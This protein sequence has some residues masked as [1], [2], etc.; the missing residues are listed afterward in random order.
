MVIHKPVLLKESIERLNLKSE[1][2]AVD[3]TLGGGGHSIG[4]LNIIGRSGKLV[5]IDQDTVAVENFRQKNSADN[6]ILV[7]DNFANL[8][9]VLTEFGPPAGGEKVDAI[10]ADLGYSSMQLEDTGIGMSFLQDAPLDMRLDRD[11]KLS[12]K[13][14]VNTYSQG[15]LS[16]LI[17]NFGEERFASIIAKRIVDARKKKEIET[18][19]DL[20]EIIN[21]AIP[22]KFKHGKLHPATKTFQ[23]LRIEVNHELEVLEKFIPQAIEALNPG[24]RL[25]IISFHSLED[26]IV[27]DIFRTHA[28]GCICPADFPICQCGQMAKVKII[29]K[30]PVEPSVEEIAENPRSRSAKLRVCEK[31]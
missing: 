22:E 24:G 21:T 7:K 20:V 9:N 17:K 30:K 31:L 4:M 19:T 3:A 27:K 11:G 1:S 28:R 18:T 16:R 25:A 6:V 26:R 29:T 13:A 15:E 2:I 14:V 10:L 12:A 23:A 5:G 8:K